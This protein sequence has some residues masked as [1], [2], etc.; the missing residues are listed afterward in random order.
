[1][2]DDDDWATA[3][4][5]YRRVTGNEYTEKDRDFI[6]SVRQYGARCLTCA[7]FIGRER[8]RGQRIGTMSYFTKIVLEVAK[9]QPDKIQREL[10]YHIGLLSQRQP[11]QP[12]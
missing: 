5:I 3:V 6:E 1:M 11:R 12:R 9:W 4:E 7:V 8:K 10:Q 2:R